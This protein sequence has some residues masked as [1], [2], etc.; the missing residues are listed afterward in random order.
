MCSSLL[1]TSSV[2]LGLALC[3]SAWAETGGKNVVTDKRQT[4]AQPAKRVQYYVLSSASAIP[5]PIEHLNGAYPTTTRSM[6]IIGRRHML[7]RND[8]K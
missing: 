6:I 7:A 8:G 1:R 2:V 4:A 5:T 3:A